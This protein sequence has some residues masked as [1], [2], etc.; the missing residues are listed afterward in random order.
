MSSKEMQATKA[1]IV[2]MM[3]IGFAPKFDG[4]FDPMQ[5]R[6]TI[7]MAQNNMYV[8]PGV[9]F[10]EEKFSVMDAELCIPDN[11]KDDAIV[12]YIHGGGLIC[13]NAKS[14]RGYSSLI[15]KET[16]CKTY[17]F[18]YRLAPE[19]PYPAGVEDC[20]L[21]YKTI[22]DNN[23]EKPVVLI[24][25][26]GGAYLS[27]VTTLKARDNGL[28]MPAAVIPYSVVLDVSG[29][30]DRNRPDTEDNTVT[31]DGL[32]RLAELYCPDESLRTAAYC[33]PYYADFTG[34]APTLL[35]WDKKE[36]LAPDNEYLVEVLKK[37]N[38]EV[39]Y[40]AYDDCF[41][42]F[43]TTGKGTPES[44]EVLNNTVAFIEKHIGR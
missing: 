30:L 38:V 20:F 37:N 2:K 36:T 1:M 5:L 25:E 42:A 14:S 8:E 17:S 12:I 19:D 21:A 40:K 29:K 18:S 23:P 3:S 15:A 41:H 27:V 10:V 22:T 39:E 44:L 13:G 9:T 26:S 34:F 16:G 6:R 35:A 33:S 11:D 31:A 7:E 32:N 28:R 4:G 24:G 43:A